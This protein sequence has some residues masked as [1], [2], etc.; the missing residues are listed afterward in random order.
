MAR[1]Q[2]LRLVKSRRRDSFSTGYGTYLLVADTA[3]VPDYVDGCTLEQIEA[4]LR[5]HPNSG[6]AAGSSGPD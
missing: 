2:G 4:Q 5:T 6:V 3:V 1:R